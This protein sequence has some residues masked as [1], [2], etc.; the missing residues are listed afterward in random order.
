VAGSNPIPAS[1]LVCRALASIEIIAAMPVDDDW[2]KKL[3]PWLGGAAFGA[4]MLQS[5]ID[6][7][8]KSRAE[9]EDPEGC[10]DLCNTVSEILDRW[11]PPDYDYEDEYTEDLYEFLDEELEDGIP[12]QMR[13]K[14]TRGLPDIVIN[15][16]LVLELKV[17]P[18]KTERDRLIGQCCDYSVEWVTW[19]IVIDMPEE[20]VAELRGLLEAKSLGYIDIVE[21]NLDDEEEDED[22][23]EE[24]DEEED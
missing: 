9:K 8:K 7:K 20:K 15:D 16:R 21:F 10:K 3:W 4:L 1:F 18:K 13:K 2:L 11:E 22:E 6:E 5:H 14:T 19:A 12:I 24:N 23:D 17:E